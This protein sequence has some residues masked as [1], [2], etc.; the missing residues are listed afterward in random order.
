MLIHHTQLT[1]GHQQ[2][3]PV[4][5]MTRS[6]VDQGHSQKKQKNVNFFYVGMSKVADEK[7]RIQSPDPDL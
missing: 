5:Q 1:G 6:K 4:L 2:Q 7:S 3:L